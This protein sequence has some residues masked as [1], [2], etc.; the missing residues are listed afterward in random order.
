[1]MTTCI[2]TYFPKIISFW[3]QVLWFNR[4]EERPVKQTQFPD[5]ARA[6]EPVGTRN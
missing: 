5:I 1:M 4:E 2:P 6:S 3:M